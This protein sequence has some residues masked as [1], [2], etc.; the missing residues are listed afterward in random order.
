[1]LSRDGSVGTVTRIWVGDSVIVVRFL[2]ASKISFPKHPDRPWFQPAPYSIGICKSTKGGQS[3]HGVKLA[4]NLH[5]VSK[6]RMIPVVSPYP[7]APSCLARRQ[8]YIYRMKLSAELRSCGRPAAISVRMRDQA[9]R[10][11][12]EAPMSFNLLKTKRRLLYLK[13]QFV[14]RRKRF[15]SRL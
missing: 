4:S 9:C 2:A 7:H 1:V 15:Q 13:N 6:L 12:L 14:P 5:L 3:D 8:L 10:D 11:E